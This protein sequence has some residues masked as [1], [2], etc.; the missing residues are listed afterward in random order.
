MS[1]QFVIEPSTV[2]LGVDYTLSSN[3]VSLADGENIKPVP[4]TLIHS[5][6]PKLSRSFSIRLTNST[7]GGAAIGHPSECI[8]TILETDDAHG[9]FGKHQ[10]HFL[11]VVLAVMYVSNCSLPITTH[12]E[13][14]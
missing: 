12:C 13:G 11:F 8:V 7:T 1:V 14:H 2:I 9:I 4:I 10:F 6:V 5:T 3:Q